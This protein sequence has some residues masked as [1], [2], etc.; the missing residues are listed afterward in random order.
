M[1]NI[2]FKQNLAKLRNIKFQKD[3]LTNIFTKKIDSVILVDIGPKLTLFNIDIKAGVRIDA[4]KSVKLPP[5]K[6]QEVI[7]DSLRDFIKQNNIEHKN[8]ILK[9]SLSSLLIKRI[10]LPAVPNAELPE[11]I[12]WQ[13][14]ED[15]PF[16]SSGAVMDYSIIKETTKEDGSKVMDIICAVAE[17][18]EIKHQVLLLKQSGLSCLSV[19]LLPFGYAKLIE[20]YL[21]QEKDEPL[22]IL[23][24]GD[25]ICYITIYKNNKFEFY[26]E[27]PIS[28]N[29]LRESLKGVLVSDKGKVEL[30]DEEVEEV[31]SKVGV[32]TEEASVY[33]DKVSSSQILSM[34]RQI[35]E[36]LEGEI[37]RSLSYYDSKFGAGAVNKIFIAGSALRIPN[38]EEFLSKEL[39]LEVKKFSLKDKLTISSAIDQESLQEGYAG[40][41]LVLD[42]Q[43]NINLLPHEFRTE[44]FEKLERVSLRWVAFITFLLLVT[45]YLFA[46][47]GIGAYQ[48]RLDNVLVHL[49][50]LSE[51]RQIKTKTDQLNNFVIDVKNS[52]PPVATILKKLSNIATRELFFNDFSLNSDSKT[53]EI[54]GIVKTV[55][56][57]PDSILTKFIRDMEASGCFVDVSISS[58]QKSK[59]QLIETA[60]FQ[61]SFKLP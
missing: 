25:N 12:K 5:D 13:I 30:S 45:P 43:E 46:R 10:Q 59:Q 53:G 17:E 8:A 20:K 19:G 55:K 58:V 33:K 6:K 14:K 22:G 26:R 29:R 23:H 40:L 60:E 3:T 34:I 35:L 47:G 32:P 31:L 15:L 11:A 54:S 39:S 16:E 42:Y 41:G 1:K 56:Q 51:V 2:D 48:K 57:N 52:E 21:K 44:K 61:I 38:I 24:L 50:V 28:I 4:F 9:P 36:R 27:L 49:N 18:K 7:L 37:R